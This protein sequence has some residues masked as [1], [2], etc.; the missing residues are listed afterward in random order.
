VVTELNLKPRKHTNSHEPLAGDF[1]ELKPIKQKAGKIVY[2]RAVEAD[3]K[4]ASIKSEFRNPKSQILPLRPS[5]P[6]HR[7]NDAD[8]M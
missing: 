8:L 3:R 6:H 5:R 2:A 7:T 1:F 4:S